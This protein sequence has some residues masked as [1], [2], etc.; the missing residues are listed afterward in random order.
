MENPKETAEKL[1][2]K[3]DSIVGPEHA[4]KKLNIL[5][6]ALLYDPNHSAALEATAWGFHEVGLPEASLGYLN[7]ALVHGPH[8]NMAWTLAE[9]IV[10]QIHER[11]PTPQAKNNLVLRMREFLEQDY[12]GERLK[13]YP[14]S[15]DAVLIRKVNKEC[16]A[17]NMIERGQLMFAQTEFH[18][19]SEGKDGH[20]PN[21][22]KPKTVDLLPNGP[23]HI[24]SDDAP[25]HKKLG[26][27]ASISGDGDVTIASSTLQI[28]G[29]YSIS[30]FSALCKENRDSFFE[31]YEWSKFGQ[32]AVVIR[33]PHEFI[34]QVR[35]AMIQQQK[36][37]LS[38]G[39]V[40]Y[41]PKAALAAFFP[42]IYQ[43]FLKS[44]ERFESEF[45]YRFA[46]NN[47]E[48]G[49][50]EV[51]SISEIAEIVPTEN[52]KVRLSELFPAED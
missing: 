30:C 6:A 14:L 46:L 12:V 16:Y 17:K 18:R 15:G 47:R 44:V 36:P 48:I 11:L 3:A 43:P 19:Q 52:L 28:G 39:L 40:T 10:R 5:S 1:F 49:L 51:G 31:K 35:K 7:L 50:V 9:T 13:H 23:L 27:G 4:K 29:Q 21:E 8:S 45:E 22:N 34:E 38:S 41:L 24:G 42:A 25:F 26:Y 32:Y 20:D 2:R 33:R 37:Y